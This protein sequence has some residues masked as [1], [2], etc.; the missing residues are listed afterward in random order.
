MIVKA[1]TGHTP[2]KTNS[3]HTGYVEYQVAHV[4]V[5]SCFL[6]AR[7]GRQMCYVN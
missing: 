5:T 6:V 3:V 7:D 1:Q 4:S 2:R